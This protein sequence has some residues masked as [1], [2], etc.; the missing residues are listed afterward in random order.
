MKLQVG[1]LRLELQECSSLKQQQ[2]S[3]LCG[4]FLHLEFAS[5]TTYR[6]SSPKAVTREVGYQ[7]KIIVLTR[8]KIP[9]LYVCVW[10]GGVHLLLQS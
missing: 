6:Y 4:N 7:R 2:H 1:Y 10:G 9:S 5:P 8:V 3:A